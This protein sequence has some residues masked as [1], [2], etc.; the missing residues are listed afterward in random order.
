VRVTRRATASGQVA[1]GVGVGLF[2]AVAEEADDVEEPDS[3]AAAPA[4]YV[5]A[6]ATQEP[7]ASD[8]APAAEDAENAD[9]GTE[10]E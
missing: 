7:E 8:E 5:V 10:E 2:E 4:E 9:P 6:E 3:E 1:P